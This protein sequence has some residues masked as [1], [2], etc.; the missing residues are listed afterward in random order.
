MV[1]VLVLLPSPLFVLVVVVVTTVP[2]F[3]VL[4]TVFSLLV[5]FSLKNAERR[6]L[7]AGEPLVFRI[8]NRLLDRQVGK[9]SHCLSTNKG[10][11][12]ARQNHT[13]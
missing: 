6:A 1:L 13:A 10:G 4:T 2:S 3:F 9:G 5:A 7:L 8:G 12:Q 11:H